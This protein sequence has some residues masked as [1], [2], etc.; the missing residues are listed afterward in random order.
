[1]SRTKRTRR[2][3]TAEQKAELLRRHIVE[4]SRSPIY[5]TS[6][7]FSGVVFDD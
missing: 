6:Q 2:Q 3:F 5:A 1:M 4:K 7:G